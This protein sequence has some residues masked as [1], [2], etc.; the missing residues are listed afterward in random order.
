MKRLTLAAL[1][2]LGQAT[3]IAQDAAFLRAMGE[4]VVSLELDSNAAR[5]EAVQ[6][7]LER[8]GLTFTLETFQG[9]QRG[10][11]AQSVGTNI[12][13][14]LGDGRSDIVVGGH[15]DAVSLP[16]GR[17]SR[18]AVDNAASVVILARLADVLAEEPLNH[19]VRV[20]FF[21][22]E[23]LGLI[24]SSRYVQAHAGDDIEAM[25]NLDVNGYG[26]TVFYGPVGNQPG[27]VM[28][29]S[30]QSACR[31]VMVDCV[32]FGRSP[33]S[34]HLS[35]DRAGIPMVM[36]SLLP[37]TQVEELH[38]ALNGSPEEQRALT[39]APTILSLIHTADDTSA[40]ID[41]AGMALT[42]KTLLELVRTLD[43]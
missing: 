1:C 14:T 20:V 16:D 24:G 26:D 7:I 25:V 15:Y 38:T 9:T 41:P 6:A 43:R 28:H 29:E 10:G 42:L 18:G 35:F 27:G 12:V 3:A 19:R 39:Q 22:M 34:D 13:V 40:R 11:A 32:A 5:G 36:L 21:D 30:M 31:A 33:S 17:L 37:V 4:D 8:L 23:E 2:V